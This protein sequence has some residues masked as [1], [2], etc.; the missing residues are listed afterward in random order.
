M[1]QVILSLSLSLSLSRIIL[2]I[3]ILFACCFVLS[4]TEIEENTEL[5][6][7]MEKRGKKSYT[8][9]NCGSQ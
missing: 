7:E 5:D 8:K 1:L 9:N 3:R 6:A 2:N 4:L